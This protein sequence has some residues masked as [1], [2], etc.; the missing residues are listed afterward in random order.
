MKRVMCSLV[1]LAGLLAGCSTVGNVKVKCVYNERQCYDDRDHPSIVY[2]TKDVSA[3]GLEKVYQALLPEGSQDVWVHE[4]APA[5]FL[6]QLPTNYKDFEVYDPWGGDDSNVSADISKVFGKAGNLSL[7]SPA[8][9]SR[10]DGHLAF[11]CLYLPNEKGTQFQVSKGC[12]PAF[13]KEWREQ[14]DQYAQELLAHQTVVVLSQANVTHHKIYGTS[15]YVNISDGMFDNMLGGTRFLDGVF[16]PLV[17]LWEQRLLSSP[18]NTLFITVLAALTTE[19]DGSMERTQERIP[20]AIVGSKNPAALEREIF[21]ILRKT[22]WAKEDET[23]GRDMDALKFSVMTRAD[24][25]EYVE[26]NYPTETQEE[27]RMRIMNV[28]QERNSD[29]YR[30]ISLDK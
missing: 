17:F 29:V 14:L 24:M 28:V 22:D 18:K 2:M 25:P 3:A 26:R 1:V 9:R 11:T 7:L 15:S 30:V 4:Y 16:N 21:N 8:K 23:E 27:K 10:L 20:I 6:F 5:S 13:W 12:D 19:D